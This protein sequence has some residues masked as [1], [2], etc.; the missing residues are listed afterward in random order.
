MSSPVDYACTNKVLE[1]I[2]NFPFVSLYY[3]LGF[4]Q[5]TVVKRT[6][7]V[8]VSIILILVLCL[9][10]CP[11]RKALHVACMSHVKITLKHECCNMHVAIS[12]YM[13]V[14]CNTQGIGMLF[15]HATCMDITCMLHGCF[16]HATTLMLH[17]CYTQTMCMLHS[18]YMH[19]ALKWHA[20][21]MH[22][23]CM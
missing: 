11:S 18:D 2:N 22:V 4:T 1:T 15:M 17:A 14:S 21:H 20:C 3:N 6:L 8:T 16:L 7:G 10:V 23:T 12:L 9:R 5:I 19:V 13:H